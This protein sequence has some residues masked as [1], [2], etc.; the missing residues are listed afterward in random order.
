MYPHK[1][2][3]SDLA[4]LG[5]GCCVNCYYLLCDQQEH[6]TWSSSSGASS[7][8][9]RGSPSGQPVSKKKMPQLSYLTLFLITLAV[10]FVWMD[11]ALYIN[12][13]QVPPLVPGVPAKQENISDYSYS[14]F[15]PISVK[16]LFQGPTI[17][18]ID[19][20]AA[21]WTVAY[22][23][24]AGWMSANAVSVSGVLTAF[25]AA[26]LVISDSL[27]IRQLGVVLFKVS[28]VRNFAIAHRIL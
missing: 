20:P 5:Q 1:G 11:V 17:H 26:R 21:F 22:T 15:Y 2:K 8:N 7:P 4:R 27:K 10:Y 14:P 18:Y 6:F 25:L 19:T 13:Q 12:L 9:G 16:L 24:V 3:C 23:N 28:L